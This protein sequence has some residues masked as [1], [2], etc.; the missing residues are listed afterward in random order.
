MVAELK[1]RITDVAVLCRR[2]HVRELHLFGSS[3]SASSVSEVGDLD[4]LV[5]FADMPPALYSNSYFGLAEGLS[6]LFGC[7]VDLVEENAISNPFFRE[8]VDAVKE[9]IYGV[10]FR[11]SFI[12]AS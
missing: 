2:F 4:F 8:A 5:R 11:Y 3:T 9:R 7:Q 10:A 1:E 6:E 12:D